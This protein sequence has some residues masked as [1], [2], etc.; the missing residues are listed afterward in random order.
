[1]KRYYTYSL[2]S[3]NKVLYFGMTNE[4]SRRIFEHKNRL[5][6]GFTKKYCE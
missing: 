5:V 2:A 3:E 4:L 6:D 1:M